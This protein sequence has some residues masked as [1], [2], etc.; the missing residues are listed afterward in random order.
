M[1]MA[2]EAWSPTQAMSMI[3]T[4]CQKVLP[5]HPSIGVRGDTNTT[6]Q[7]TQC[8]NPTKKSSSPGLRS[9]V[10]HLDWGFSRMRK[11]WMDTRPLF[12]PPTWPGYE[13]N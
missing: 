6:R 1:D 5:V 13:T 9:Y 2:A 7:G 3:R 8:D 11:Q 12:P 10:A 4:T